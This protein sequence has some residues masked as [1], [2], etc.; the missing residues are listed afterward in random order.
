MLHFVHVFTPPTDRKTGPDEQRPFF[1]PEDIPATDDVSAAQR[2]VDG[3]GR[4]D[5]MDST[6][7]S[8]RFVAL[9]SPPFI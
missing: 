8:P 4:Q 6:V 3:P 9:L 1:G 5:D 2:H 7:T